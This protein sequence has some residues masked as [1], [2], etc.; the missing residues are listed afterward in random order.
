MTYTAMGKVTSARLDIA[1]RAL[2]IPLV[3]MIFSILLPIEI[4]FYIG[5]VFMTSIRVIMIGLTIPMLA[6]LVM[7]RRRDLADWL[8]VLAVLWICIGHLIKRGASGIEIAGQ[9]ILEILIPYLVA[10]YCL[11]DKTEL[12]R[13]LSAIGFIILVLG[14]LAIPESVLG[15]RFLHEIP[16]AFT[17]IVYEIQSDER[18]GL[19]RASSTFENPILFGLFGATF[20]A[21]IWYS[22]LPLSRRLIL[23]AGCT[24]STVLSLS[25][26]AILM[27]GLQI[28]LI[29]IEK[30]TRR[31]PKRTLIIVISTVIMIVFV[32]LSS[33]RGFIKL[34]ISN[35]TL[36]PSTGYYRTLQWENA[37][38]DV[39][40]HKFLGMTDVYNWTRPFWMTPSIDNNWLVLSM[41]SGIPAT[42]LVWSLLLRISVVLYRLKRNINDIAL[43]RTMTGW[44]ISLIALFLGAWTV[45][46]FGRM[47]PVS[48]FIYG[49]GAALMCMGRPSEPAG[50]A[51]TT[52]TENCRPATRYSRFSPKESLM[53]QP[54]RG[55][56][57]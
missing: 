30:I 4:S 8:V 38:D 15:V 6:H 14:I 34:M 45:A 24:L 57:S 11:R 54:N 40:A 37:I 33:N 52:A 53:G 47:Q 25:S 27:L 42:L 7:D 22:E 41:T 46:Y 56:M 43:A 10:R 28:L 17:G 26:A 48:Y 9:S 13:F 32:E 5:P 55:N 35:I 18:M 50:N 23:C 29:I 19:L 39:M 16:R 31:L 2:P 21:L 20:M 36:N 12:T 44:L 1:R 49:I 51:Q 3:L